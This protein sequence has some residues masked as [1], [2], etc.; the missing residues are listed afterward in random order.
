M[1]RVEVV[2]HQL[3]VQIEGMDKLWSLKGRLEIPLTHVTGA[4]ADPEAVRD[5][6]GWRGPGT[7]V[8]AIVVAGTFH[9]QGDREFWDVHDAAKAVVIRLTD[10]RYARLVV[11]VDDPAQTVAAIRQALGT[12]G[13]GSEPV[14]SHRAVVEA[15]VEG[16]R[17]SDHEAI[18]ACLTDDVEW[19]LHGY[20]ALRGKAAFD[21]EIESD[22][23]VGSPTLHLDRLIEEGDTVVAIGSGEMTLKEA[24]RVA[25]V[26]AEVFTFT[27]G[28]ISRLETFHIN[29][30]GR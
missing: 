3:R 25:F 2:G 22:A 20:R 13:E 30:G 28:R 9:H 19:V 17:R 11:G 10:E 21:G 24:G 6:K 14:A 26:F 4:E 16:F 7:H 27:G 23:A 5:W 18:L 8:P 15:Y 12:T 29:L 1:A